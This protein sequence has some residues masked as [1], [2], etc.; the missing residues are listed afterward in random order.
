MSAFEITASKLR[1]WLIPESNWNELE[2][3][4]YEQL[5]EKLS[6]T[7]P[8]KEEVADYLRDG[9]IRIGFHEQYLSG[10]GWTFLRN[11]T[12]KPARDPQRHSREHL[13]PVVLSLIVHETF[14]LKQSLW[15]RLS[16]QGE[17]RAWQFQKRM[18]PSIAN[19]K[20]NEI[21]AE[22]EAYGG[23][24]EHWDELARLSPDSREDLDAA[25]EV[26]KR[27]AK[28]YRSDRLPLFPLPQEIGYLLRRGN[29][30]EAVRVVL[31][32]LRGND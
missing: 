30:I 15:M 19:T 6:I 29:I 12:L 22:G 31:S 32:L 3:S 21:G 2:I 9:N 16:M 23:T 7:D 8:L 4:Q 17:L 25:R 26:M 11:I 10:A 14:H 27:V 5:L 28:G 13:D 20:G 1:E 18:Y 24:K